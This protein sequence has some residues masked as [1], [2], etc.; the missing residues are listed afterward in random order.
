MTDEITCFIVG[1]VIGFLFFVII[2]KTP[3]SYY[4]LGQIDAYNGIYKYELVK[5]NDGSVIWKEK[6]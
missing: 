6:K 4:K 1:V 5:Q 3:D 2:F